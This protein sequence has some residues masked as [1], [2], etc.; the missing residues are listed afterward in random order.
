MEQDGLRRRPEGRLDV[1]GSAPSAPGD[2]RG[3]TTKRKQFHAPGL[4]NTAEEA[5]VALEIFKRDI[6]ERNG[7]KVVVPEQQY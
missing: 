5:A 1:P 6:K 2:G 3:G 4:F 7:G